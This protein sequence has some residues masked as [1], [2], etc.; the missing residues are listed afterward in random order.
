M[1]HPSKPAR[2][3]AVQQELRQLAG[4]YQAWRDGLPANLQE[5]SLAAK[6]DEAVEQLEDLAD[7]VSYFDYPQVG[8]GY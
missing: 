3:L 1:K 7:E 2:L 4:E 8:I 6:L 5:G